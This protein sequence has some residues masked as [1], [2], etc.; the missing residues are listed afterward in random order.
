MRVLFR[1]GDVKPL[2]GFTLIETFVATSVLLISLAAPLSIAA[3]SLRSAYYA[4]D[5]IT[6]FYLAQEAVEYIQAKR[7]QN[8]LT[9]AT[10]LTGLDECI[11]TACSIDFPNFTHTA[12]ST[13]CD[14][15]LIR[16]TDKLFVGPGGSGTPSVFTR[17]VRIVAVTTDEVDIK[18]T[19]SWVSAGI[20]RSF[21]ISE[22]LFNWLGS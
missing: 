15:L 7:D 12:C 21:Q 19:V 4:R 9:S 1:T 17:S 13:T 20:S 18:V 2:R 8:Y 5:Q 22:H 3:Q 10:W 11:S 6:A 14:P 16:D